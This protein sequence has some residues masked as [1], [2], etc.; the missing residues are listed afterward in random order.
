MKD[1]LFFGKMLTPKNH[2]ICVL[3]VTADG[4]SLWDWSNVYRL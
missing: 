2:H 4:C 1:I 3:A